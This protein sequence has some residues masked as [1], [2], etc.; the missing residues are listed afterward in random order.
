[1]LKI[2]GRLT[3]EKADDDS[4][5]ISMSVPK[6]DGI[7]CIK[8]TVRNEGDLLK[9]MP[10]FIK[11]TFD[12]SEY[13]FENVFKEDSDGVGVV[14]VAVIKSPPMVKDVDD[15]PLDQMTPL[16][17]ERNKNKMIKEK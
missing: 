13:E 11:Q 16:M 4:F 15:T 2:D 8:A 3:I 5:I 7:D 12:G 1:M 10:E 17:R 14:E 9:R 6:G